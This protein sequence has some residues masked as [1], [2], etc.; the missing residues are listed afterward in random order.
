M[1]QTLHRVAAKE[2]EEIKRTTMQK[3]ARRHHKEGGNP[4]DQKSH[5]QKAGQYI[6][7]GLH[8]AVD[9]QSLGER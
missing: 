4:L 6:D 9:G 1:D 3:M 5:R 7:G 8:P 2:K